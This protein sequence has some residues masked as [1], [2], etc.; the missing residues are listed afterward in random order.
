ML[1]QMA[2]MPKEW[3]CTNTA[4]REAHTLAHVCSRASR[5]CQEKEMQTEKFE[6]HG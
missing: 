4:A 6:G 3:P 5:S 2:L 1:S